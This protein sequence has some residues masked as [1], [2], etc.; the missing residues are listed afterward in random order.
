MASFLGKINRMRNLRLHAANEYIYPNASLYHEIV[1]GI[2]WT[3]GF[4][5]VKPRRINTHADKL[6][7]YVMKKRPIYRSYAWCPPDNGGVCIL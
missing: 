6:L 4:S 7:S 5:R 1:Q 2:P 3:G